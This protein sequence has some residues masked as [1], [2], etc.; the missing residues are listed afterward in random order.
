MAALFWM[1]GFG[2]GLVVFGDRSSPPRTAP[3][4][5]KTVAYGDHIMLLRYEDTNGWWPWGGKWVVVR[6]DHVS[7][8]RAEASTPSPDPVLLPSER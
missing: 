5:E 4:D 2:A 6:T 1:M 3:G 7:A 8:P